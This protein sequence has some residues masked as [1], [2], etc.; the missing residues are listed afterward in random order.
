VIEMYAITGHPAPPLPAIAPLREIA[1]DGLAAVCA[2]AAEREDV[3]PDALWRHE[4]V[5]EALMAD[6]DL[7]PVRFGTRL[8][9]DAAAARVLGERH[10]ELAAALARV[11]GAVELSLRVAAAGGDSSATM[12]SQQAPDGA[13]YLRARARTDR[14]RELALAQVHEPLAELARAVVQHPAR[15]PSELLR[16]AY[17]IDRRDVDGFTRLVARLQ[18]ADAT[19]Q[20]L[21]TGPWP[22]YSFA[23]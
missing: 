9:D 16:A 18:D 11:R 8:D 19:F 6:R 1:A 12:R 14:A 2:P 7:L 21:C 3:T 17:L 4:G 10:A 22:P 13:A 5:V 15:G 20:L 23:R